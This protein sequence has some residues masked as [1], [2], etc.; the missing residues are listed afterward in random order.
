MQNRCLWRCIIARKTGKTVTK[1]NSEPARGFAIA[2]AKMCADTRCHNVAVLDVRALS[3][4]CDYLVI[5]S[6][7][8]K[9]QMHTVAKD[10]AELGDARNY[11]P[12]HISGGESEQWIL[13][14][15]V[16]VVAH[17][18]NDE[19]RNFYDLDN[20]WGDAPR[21]EWEKA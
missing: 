6:G 3:P 13:V 19:S 7:T 8:S 20:L 4:V 2:A 17:V 21:V 1:A 10:L 16:H 5:A 9:R 14:D 18:F 12:Y 11:A 15:F